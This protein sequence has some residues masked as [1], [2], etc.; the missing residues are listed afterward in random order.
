MKIEFDGQVIKYNMVLTYI[1]TG[2]KIDITFPKSLRLKDEQNLKILQ[3][4]ILREHDDVITSMVVKV[5]KNGKAK[6]DIT[7]T[8]KKSVDFDSLNFSSN[9]TRFEFSR[10]NQVTPGLSIYQDFKI[11]A[12]PEVILID[13]PENPAKSKSSP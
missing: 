5:I 11:I 3:N 8:F 1:D 4:A 12:D 2:V 9:N 10:R 7:F 6:N 13:V